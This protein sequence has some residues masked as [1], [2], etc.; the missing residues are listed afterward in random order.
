[1]ERRT[2]LGLLRLLK[3]LLG[4]GALVVLLVILLVQV[5]QCLALYLEQPTYFSGAVV[6]QTKTNFPAMTVCPM[7]DGYKEQVLQ[8]SY[9]YVREISDRC[10]FFN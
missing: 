3:G 5:Y 4:G 7:D 9:L 2:Q 10:V 1:M 8:V 6:H